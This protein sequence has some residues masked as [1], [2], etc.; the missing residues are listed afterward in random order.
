MVNMSPKV[1][2]ETGVLEYLK[3]VSS[4]THSARY[5]VG[6]LLGKAERF[7][8]AGLENCNASSE[9]RCVGQHHVLP[10]RCGSLY[11]FVELSRSRTRGTIIYAKDVLCFGDLRQAWQA[12]YDY[13]GYEYHSPTDPSDFRMVYWV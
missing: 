2:F 13:F 7:E 10:V 4:G 5:R 1:S 3:K 9:I 11:A 8:G 6:M 12:V